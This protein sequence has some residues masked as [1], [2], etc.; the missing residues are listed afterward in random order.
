M[1]RKAIIILFNIGLAASPWLNYPVL[2]CIS[3]LSLIL[4]TILAAYSGYLKLG[5]PWVVT[6]LLIIAVSYLAFATDS[7]FLLPWCFLLYMVAVSL[8]G[9]LLKWQAISVIIV[10]FVQ[11]LAS[12]LN[13]YNHDALPLYKNIAPAVLT[14]TALA[15]PLNWRRF[16]SVFWIVGM[17]F[18][19]SDEGLVAIAFLSITFLFKR[20][21]LIITP[22][23]VLL[24]LLFVLT[25]VGITQKI[26]GSSHAWQT[27]KA[28]TINTETTFD[29]TRLE[30][31]QKALNNLKITG[32]SPGPG[33]VPIHNL[34]LFLA[35]N[36]GIFAGL[37]WLFLIGFA[38][39]KSR[40]SYLFVAII[41]F[42]LFDHLLID[43]LPA[44]TFALMGLIEGENNG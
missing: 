30:G 28:Q 5:S 20:D 41:A 25:P 31:Y 26:W 42:S 32:Q 18:T 8:K 14:L 11:V 9:E 43:Q 24:C 36:Y 7:L 38:L 13:G 33:E 12:I 37:A 27:V 35:Y 17:F 10:T 1:I 39:W 44:F 4:A 2:L 21:W 34:P 15:V 23:V 40:F 3:Y 19:G 6:P 22:V 29:T 16:I